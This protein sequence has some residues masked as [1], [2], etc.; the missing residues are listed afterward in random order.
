MIIAGA[1]AYPRTIDF[2]LFREIADEVGA[3]LLVDMAHIAGLVATGDHPSPSGYAHFIT[4]TTHKT[5][6]GAR[7]GM[8]LCDQE[9]AKLI[10]SKIFPGLQGGPLC[11]IIAA[12]AVAFKEAQ[13]KGY[14]NYIKQVIKN[15]Q[16]LANALI[17]FDFRLTTD[18]TDNHL[19]LIDLTNKGVTGKEAEKALDLANITVNKNSIPFEKRSPFITSGIRLGTPA[20]TSR[21]LKEEDMNQVAE[22]INQVIEHYDDQNAINKIARKVREFSRS[23][24]EFEDT[25]EK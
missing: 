20:L 3:Y 5:L 8:I 21:G 16:T 17:G 10:N 18:G 6:R 1:S 13:T 7:G 2:K 19:M 14:Q 11:N 9:N 24:P 15:A 22:F 12:K 4:S 23:F 25:I